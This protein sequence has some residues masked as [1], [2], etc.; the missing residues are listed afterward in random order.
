MYADNMSHWQRQPTCALSETYV[1]GAPNFCC[2]HRRG[3]RACRFITR[4]HTQHT[5]SSA[6]LGYIFKCDDCLMHAAHVPTYNHLQNA[7]CLIIH[8]Y[9]LILS[10][11]EGRNGYSVHIKKCRCSRQHWNETNLHIFN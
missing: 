5:I 1:V 8:T 2:R 9:L 11:Q 3:R 7:H 6:L 10:G 4:V